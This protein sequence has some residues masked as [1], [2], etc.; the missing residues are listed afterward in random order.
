MDNLENK[1]EI[2]FSNIFKLICKEGI[3]CK[4]KLKKVRINIVEAIDAELFS[5]DLTYCLF[6]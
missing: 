1:L 6:I 4:E 3:L 2:I 5:S